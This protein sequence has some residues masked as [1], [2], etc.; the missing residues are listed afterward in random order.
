MFSEIAVFPF[1][2]G[3]VL[4]GAKTWQKIPNA[5]YPEILINGLFLGFLFIGA[6][7]TKAI[8]FYILFLFML[9][10]L[11]R[12]ISFLRSKSFDHALRSIFFLFI[13]LSVAMLFMHS[14]KSLNAHYNGRYIY[15]PNGARNLYGITNLRTDNLTKQRLQESFE[16]T[17]GAELIL[18][19]EDN[20]NKKIVELKNQGV[21][22]EDID[23]RLVNLSLKKVATHPFRFSLFYTATGL[24]MLFWEST[25]TGFVIYPLWLDKIFSFTPFAIGLKFTMP[26]L[27]LA[28]LLYGV[29]FIWINRKEMFCRQGPEV[30][31]A[32]LSGNILLLI[33]TFN[34]LHACFLVLPRFIFPVA[35]LY[36]ILISF[37]FDRVLLTK[38]KSLD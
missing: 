34:L 13:T 9:P 8:F 24:K 33:F 14:M 25:K 31:H 11:F 32:I 26:I 37:A 3:I 35:P 28:G 30:S 23:S 4:A 17:P 22:K 5:P 1:A 2:L 7:A 27:V 36:L 19:L 12:I 10:Y 21:P 18:F 15:T 38:K 16:I 20:V 6:M 29:Y